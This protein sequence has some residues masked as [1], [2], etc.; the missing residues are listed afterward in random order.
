MKITVNPHKI[1]KPPSSH[2]SPSEKKEEKPI[3]SPLDLIKQKA[4]ERQKRVEGDLVGV[5]RGQNEREKKKKEPV[6]CDHFE[7]DTAAGMIKRRRRR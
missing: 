7:I 6:A 2:S 1:P 4:S 3:E 5:K